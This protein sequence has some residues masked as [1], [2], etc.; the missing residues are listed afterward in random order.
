MKRFSLL[1]QTILLLNLILM[2]LSAEGQLKLPF[3]KSK[4]SNNPANLELTQR[5]GPWLIMCTSFVGEEGLEQARRLARELREEHKLKAYIY[6][7]EFDFTKEVADKG[8]GWEVVETADKQKRIRPIQMQ[9]ASKSKFE[10]IAVLVGDFAGVDDSKAQKTLEQIKTLRPSTM[11]NLDMRSAIE[12][13]NLAGERLLAWRGFANIMNSDSEAKEMGPLRAA[14][15]LPNPTLPDEYFQARKV[16]HFVLD[17]NKK[18]KKHGLLKNPGIYTVKLATFCGE[19]S[20]DL[21]K[22]HEKQQEQSW[23]IKNKKSLT[24]SKLVD[25]AKKATLL[26]RELRA[27][28]IE[29]YEFHD[30]H[31]S[32]VCVGSFD[33]LSQVDAAGNKRSN[34]DIVETIL[35]FKGSR[36]DVPGKPG[37]M[38]SY[39]LS[40]RL[41]DAGIA[42]DPQPIPVLVPK[43]SET[44]VSNR[45]LGSFR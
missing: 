18:F 22:I 23:R 16:D 30:R 28:G 7:H 14:F 6:R 41:T 10:E 2:P 26:T 32:Y 15:L 34:P 36:V 11:A 20:L 5:S 17:L 43:V 13:D 45:F 3:G 37:A 33:W 40:K 19:V 29:A 35:K 39:K 1:T 42:C 4:S 38:Q 8:V 21:N 24:S 27:K 31:E 44:R 9:T 25:A 12:G